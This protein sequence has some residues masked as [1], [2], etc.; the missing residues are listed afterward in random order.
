MRERSDDRLL[1]NVTRQV[2]MHLGFAGFGASLMYFGAIVAVFLSI[3]WKPQA[4]LYFL[5]PLLPMQ[6]ARYWLH[7]YPFG[8]KLVDVLLL[9]VLIGVL[10]HEKRPRFVASPLGKVIVLFCVVTYISLWKGAFYLGGPLPLALDDPRFSDWKNYV[11]MMFLF[12]IAAAAI[13]TPKQM[14]V[15]LILMCIS[16]LIV[17]RSFHGTLAGRDL[18]Q[19]SYEVRDAGPLGYAGENGM[20]AF[21]A[22]FSVLLIGLVAFANKLK[23]KVALWCVLATCIYCLLFTFSR[24]GYLGFLVGLLVLG[25]LKQRK[26][27]VV[28]AVILVS[29]QAIVPNAVR[30]RVLMTYSAGDGLDSSAEERVDLWEDAF[31]VLSHDPVLGTGFDTYKF[32]GRVGPYQDTHNYYVKILLEMGATG[33]LLFLFMLGAA[34]TTAW[35]LFR[36]ATDPFLSAL[37]CSFFAML[38]CAAALNFFGDRWSY[39]QVNGFFW[40]LLGMVARGLFIVKQGT[41][42]SE[43]E[44]QPV[45]L[46]SARPHRISAA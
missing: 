27:L 25:L 5:V 34:A 13:R 10:I 41:E 1:P 30:Q 15:V 21:Q 16:V 9:A 2:A 8:E 43:P 33:L 36:K 35:N 38:L 46:I 28:L 39:L 31:Q 45:E 4:G 32:M 40:I 19:F 12:W 6:T 22:Q 17:N 11:E 37:G 29:W 20:G 7:T 26:L 18:S 24:G 14:K 3:F 44:L 42:I 23:T